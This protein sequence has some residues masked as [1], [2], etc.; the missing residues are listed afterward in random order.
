MKSQI[1]L[2]FIVNGHAFGWWWL[3]KE[4][5][6]VVPFSKTKHHI[7]L[8]F[9]VYQRINRT[10]EKHLPVFYN[11]ADYSLTGTSFGLDEWD[12]PWRWSSIYF[13]P[14]HVHIIKEWNIQE[15]TNHIQGAIQMGPCPG[16]WGGPGASVCPVL[17][18]VLS[19]SRAVRT[20]GWSGDR[21]QE[22]G[23]V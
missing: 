21:D 5:I 3:N 18:F 19:Q 8:L 23:L 16:L 1:T 10:N 14:A 20:W 6:E 22:K 4:C 11:S 7:L 9:N 13:Y 2:A 17:L 15:P 12:T